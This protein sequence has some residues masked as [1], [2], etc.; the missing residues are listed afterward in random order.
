M[1]RM[2]GWGWLL[3]LSLPLLVF[4]SWSRLGSETSRIN[5]E[6]YENEGPGN[7]FEL[8]SA[9]FEKTRQ[10]PV[11]GNFT[12]PPIPPKSGIKAWRVQPDGIFKVEIDAR[13]DG[14]A[15]VLLYV[16]RVGKASVIYDC[17]STVSR[18]HVRK[19]CLE[20]NLRSMDD[21]PA[22]LAANS[23]ALKNLPPVVAATGDTNPSGVLSGSVFVAQGDEKALN[24]CGYNCVKPLSCANERPLLCAKIM[25]EN[26][27]RFLELRT[28]TAMH[29][30]INLASEAAASNACEQSV[31]AGWAI[32]QAGDL[33]GKGKAALSGEYWLH[34]DR[35]TQRNC[36]SSKS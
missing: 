35:N 24:D 4:F 21:I 34:D 22:Q 7:S 17:V 2:R 20:E 19:M 8:L 15:V 18:V 10:L 9:H 29:R 1:D 30:A 36:W 28:S 14:Q 11:E 6:R 33:G 26:F 13:I 23:E 3:A 5:L 31:G 16:P 27:V 32:A 25:D 12:L